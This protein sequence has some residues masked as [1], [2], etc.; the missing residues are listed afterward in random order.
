MLL[1]TLI[2]LA[3]LTLILTAASIHSILTHWTDT[4]GMLTMIYLCM[5]LGV[6]LG[7][8]LTEVADINFFWQ[9]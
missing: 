4:E 3:I 1:L 6:L 5:I 9:R 7:W 2:I 8:S